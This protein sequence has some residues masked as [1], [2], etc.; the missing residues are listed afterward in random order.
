MFNHNSLVSISTPS[1]QSKLA[2][3]RPSQPQPDALF[4]T[5]L[6]REVAYKYSLAA[7]ADC[8]PHPS[9]WFASVL[10]AGSVLFIE[11]EQ[12]RWCL[13]AAAG[14]S[15]PFAVDVFLC[16]Q[17]QDFNSPTQLLHSAVAWHMLQWSSRG[18]QIGGTSSGAQLRCVCAIVQMSPLF[19]FTSIALSSR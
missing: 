10:K 4:T 9:D 13:A 7:I 2:Q 14:G 6:S 15:V 17:P 8:G 3:P 16:T 12:E 1:A 5:S 18:L 11:S 19:A